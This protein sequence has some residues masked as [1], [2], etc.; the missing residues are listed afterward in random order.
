VKK[1][2]SGEEMGTLLYKADLVVSR[3]GANT[4]TE[5]AALGKPCILI[6]LPWL[7]QNE[8]E[9]NARMLEKVGIAEVLLQKD[10]SGENLLALIKKM[11]KNLS[12]YRKNAANAKKL[13]CL[14]AAEK[15]A[16][17]VEEVR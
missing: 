17:L 16:D 9:K 4:I 12:S 7:Y 2:L 8:Q 10:L 13:I 15:I 1:Y 5:L 11:L 3:A 14:K 6:P